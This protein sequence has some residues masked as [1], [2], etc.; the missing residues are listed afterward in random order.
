[1]TLSYH[2][3]LQMNSLLTVRNVSEKAFT[4]LDAY[5]QYGFPLMNI[6]VFNQKIG[7]WLNQQL[8]RV[9]LVDIDV[10]GLV[11]V[12]LLMVFYLRDFLR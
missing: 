11:I 9:P 1:M 8:F 12:L 6:R 3:D 2:V 7:F 5:V 10:N 4:T